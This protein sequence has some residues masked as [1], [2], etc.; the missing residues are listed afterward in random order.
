MNPNDWHEKAERLRAEL[1]RLRGA[2]ES[3]ETTERDAIARF[4]RRE[5]TEEPAE[6]TAT[7]PL[8]DANPASFGVASA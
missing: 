6:D 8:F 5:F 4:L 2:Q 3:D 7:L 1:A